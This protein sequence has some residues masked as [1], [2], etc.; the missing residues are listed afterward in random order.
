MGFNDSHSTPNW[1]TMVL[2]FGNV[3]V[4]PWTDVGNPNP[5]VRLIGIAK[6][7]TGP[8]FDTYR[9]EQERNKCGERDDCRG[10]NADSRRNGNLL[11]ATPAMDNEGT[12]RTIQ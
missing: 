8:G 4:L 1:G 7:D 5:N 12:N 3:G 2:R 9:S 6:V 11:P 10:L